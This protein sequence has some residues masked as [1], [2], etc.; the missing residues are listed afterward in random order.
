MI[1]NDKTY[2]NLD[3]FLQIVGEQVGIVMRFELLSSSSGFIQYAMLN[4][5]DDRFENPQL[6]QSRAE[7]SN[8]QRTNRPG[9][10]S[11]IFLRTC[12]CIITMTKVH[13]C[14]MSMSW[15]SWDFATEVFKVFW[16]VIDVSSRRRRRNA[17]NANVSIQSHCDDACRKTMTLHSGSIPRSRNSTLCPMIIYTLHVFLLY[18]L[19]ECLWVRWRARVLLRLCHNYIFNNRIVCKTFDARMNECV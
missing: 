11:E 9:C 3:L 19:W 13:R 8:C 2:C 10:C 4:I 12:V 1:S 18:T 5:R 14:R 7:S 16:F 15:V 6:P 17:G